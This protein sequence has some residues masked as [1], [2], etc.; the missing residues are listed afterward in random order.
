MGKKEIIESEEVEDYD[1]KD[2]P[3]I[4][5][6]WDFNVK[7][8]E[9]VP[10]P[11]TKLNGFA[12]LI[13]VEYGRLST[14]E[15]ELL[16][17]ELEQSE[18][19]Y[20]FTAYLLPEEV[21]RESSEIHIVVPDSHQIEEL[22]NWCAADTISEI[23]GKEIPIKKLQDDVYTIELFTDIKQQNGI[24]SI[25]GVKSLIKEEKLRFTGEVWKF[26]RYRTNK[27][28]FSEKKESFFV[29]VFTIFI[30][31]SMYPFLLPVLLYA[32]FIGF[33]LLSFVIF[34]SI[35]LGSS[36]YEFENN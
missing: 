15:E 30:V 11:S 26:D 36:L 33:I 8:F 10:D 25:D 6:E 35:L 18:K 28:A 3:L 2:G 12:R 5:N 21:N 1:K 29:T 19:Y 9:S 20:V 24:Q 27:M 16:G 17:D 23:A 14:T 22:L 34:S 13:D 4:G 31:V 7:S 32:P